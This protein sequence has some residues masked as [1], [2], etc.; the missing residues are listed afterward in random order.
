MVDQFGS[1]ST[2]TTAGSSIITTGLPIY[3]ST[4]LRAAGNWIIDITNLL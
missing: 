2:F 4:N 1:S 3:D